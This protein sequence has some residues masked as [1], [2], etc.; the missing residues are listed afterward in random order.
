MAT[1]IS[2]DHL[3]DSAR[4]GYKVLVRLP[5]ETRQRRLFLL[6]GLSP[7]HVECRLSVSQCDSELISLFE[8]V[9][10]AFF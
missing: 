1:F 3:S 4:S 2:A 8:L 7:N 9:N 6:R 10:F 5:W